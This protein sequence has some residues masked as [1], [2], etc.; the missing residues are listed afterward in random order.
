MAGASRAARQPPTRPASRPPT[1]AKATPSS[2]VEGCSGA[3]SR[4]WVD[5]VAVFHTGASGT[6]FA[7]GHAEARKWLEQAQQTLVRSKNW[8]RAH[9]LEL[10]LLRREAEGLILGK[11]TD[12]SN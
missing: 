8:S 12:P 1:N 4:T 2:S 9:Q 7:D 10:V 6:G 5:A 11:E 3:D